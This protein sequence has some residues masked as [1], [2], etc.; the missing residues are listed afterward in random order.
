[1]DILDK[2]VDKRKKGYS[3]ILDKERSCIG[4]KRIVPIVDFFG[5]KAP[6]II[7]EYKK[8]SPSVGNFGLKM[9]ASRYIS[10][11]RS[12]GICRFSVLTEQDFFNGSLNDLITSKRKF[13]RCG[14]LRKDF[15]FTPDDVRI[16]YL[17]GADA[18]LLIAGILDDT[19]LR[20][21]IAQAKKFKLQTLCEVHTMDELDRVLALKNKP[22]AIGINSRNLRDFSINYNVPLRLK[23]FIP[24][25]IKTVFESGIKDAFTASLASNSG[26]DAVLVGTSIVKD[27]DINER[28]GLIKKGL[29]EGRSAQKNFFTKLYARRS[30]RFIKI[31]GITNI[32]DA[33]TAKRYGADCIGMILASSPRRVDPDFLIELEKIKILKIAVVKDP[34]TSQIEQLRHALKTGLIDCVQFHGSETPGLVESF[35]GNAYKV[36][37]AGKKKLAKDKDYVPVILYDLAKCTGSKCR[38]DISERYKTEFHGKW[39]A[40]MINPDNIGKVIRKIEPELIDVCSGIESRPGIKNKLFMRKLIHGAINE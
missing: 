14:F 30:K 28:V 2:I 24:N 39:V 20:I 19:T 17:A 25:K 18:I 13:S 21:M 38:K 3:F 11:Y 32:E 15:L 27:K 40:G 23:P 6:F 29:R 9:S 22:A 7:G 16:S 8:A 4:D 1:M 33:Q 35:K 12:A 5:Q 10:K 36:V 26:F 31:C 34:D 37:T